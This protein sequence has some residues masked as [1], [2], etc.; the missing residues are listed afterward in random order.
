MFQGIYPAAYT[1][2]TNLVHPIFLLSW[3]LVDYCSFYCNSKIKQS[4]AL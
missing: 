4:E 1:I 2:K 3:R